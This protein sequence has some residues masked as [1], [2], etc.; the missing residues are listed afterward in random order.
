[1]G[2]DNDLNFKKLLCDLHNVAISN[3][4]LQKILSQMFDDLQC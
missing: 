1:M 2:Y 3:K 4:K